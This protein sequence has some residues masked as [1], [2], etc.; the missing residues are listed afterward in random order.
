MAII[1]LD[2]DGVLATNL[3]F[4]MNKQKFQDKHTWA[5]ELRVPYPF[6]AGCVKVLNEIIET[7]DAEIVLSSDWKLHWNILELHDIFLQNGVIKSPRTSTLNIT[8]SEFDLEEER[9]YQIGEFIKKF[10]PKQYVIIDDLDVGPKMEMKE[11]EER[12]VKTRDR[13]GLKQTGIKEKILE[14]LGKINLEY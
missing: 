7:T 13:E 3:Q 4:Q 1:F 14:K 10:K 6:D 9:A 2:I 11:A 8:A 5:D 12:F